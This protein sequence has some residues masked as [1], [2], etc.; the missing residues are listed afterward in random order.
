M[1]IMFLLLLLLFL[2]KMLM[3]MMMMIMMIPEQYRAYTNNTYIKIV[4]TTVIYRA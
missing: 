3:I 4:A 1:M 2:L